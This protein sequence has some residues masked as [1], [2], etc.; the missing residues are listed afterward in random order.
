MNREREQQELENPMTEE[1]KQEV[2]NQW[3]EETESKAVESEETEPEE[4]EPEVPDEF[5][6]LLGT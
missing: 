4:M 2:L 5:E 1:Q 6:G 3:W